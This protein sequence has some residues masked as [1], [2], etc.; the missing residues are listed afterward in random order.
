MGSRCGGY[1]FY[2]PCPAPL[3]RDVDIVSEP[4]PS[5]EESGS[6]TNVDVDNAYAAP[7]ARC[8]AHHRSLALSDSVP[9]RWVT[10]IL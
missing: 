3:S 10:P 7:V 8:T 4:D 6:E 1:A 9:H 2:C 5:Q